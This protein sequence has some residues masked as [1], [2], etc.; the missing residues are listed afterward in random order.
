MLGGG[1]VHSFLKFYQKEN[2]KLYDNES[3]SYKLTFRETSE[4]FFCILDSPHP[5]ALTWEII[6]SFAFPSEL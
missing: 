4:R 1:E 3:V 5:R 6:F 2:P